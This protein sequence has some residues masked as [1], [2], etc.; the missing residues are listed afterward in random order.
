[1][2]IRERILR[3]A[4]LLLSLC[5]TADARVLRTHERDANLYT[6]VQ[7]DP[8]NDV[9]PSG[10]M[11]DGVGPCDPSAANG[12]VQTTTAVTNAVANHPGETMQIVGTGV[13]LIPVPPAKAAG[14]ALGE[15]G[16]VVR[17]LDGEGSSTVPASTL[18]PG[19][20]AGNSAPAS[21]SRINAEEQQTVNQI[22]NASGCHT[23]GTRTAGTKGGNWVGDYQPPTN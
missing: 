7:N 1:V 2:T 19:P 18:Q 14:A 17:A 3:A 15:A 5:A 11:C 10:L 16:T 9:D 4:I 23:C 21:G 8:A 20:N 13:S 12:A 6:Y 22:G